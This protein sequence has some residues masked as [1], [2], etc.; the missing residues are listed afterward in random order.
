M[1]PGDQVGMWGRELVR[2]LWGGRYVDWTYLLALGV[3]RGVLLCW[4]KRA[5]EMEEEELGAFSISCLFQCIADDFRW[6][7]TGVY[8][9]VRGGERPSFWNE[10]QCIAFRW[11]LPWCVGSDFNVVRSVEEKMGANSVVASMRVFFSFIDDLELVDFPSKAAFFVWSATLGR[12]LTLDNLISRG[13]IL[14][15]WCCKCCGDAESVAHLLVHC[16]VTHRLWMLVVAT[17]GLAWVQL[18][19]VTAV[20]Q[21]WLGFKLVGGVGKCGCLLLIVLFRWFG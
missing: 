3:A 12:I 17:F 13:H 7:F 11:G 21:S 14:V 16:L 6:A 9:P 10:L 19:S 8:G 2:E 1:S 15:N 20:M 4:D 18:V 5:V